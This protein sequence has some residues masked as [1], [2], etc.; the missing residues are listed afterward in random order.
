MITPELC[1]EIFGKPG[2]AF[3]RS[4]MALWNVPQPVLD[5]IKNA[6]KRIYCHKLMVKPLN[7][8]F[9]NLIMHCV[10]DELQTWDGCFNVRKMRGGTQMSIHSWGLAIDVNAK[11]N[12]LGV[13]PT[14]SKTFVKCFTDAG[15]DWG[16]TWTR[17][18][19]MHFQ[20]SCV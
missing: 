13:K 9:E 2:V 7:K 14:L 3:E 6:P 11:T 1:E 18:D 17:K 8:A 15:F 5:R 4:Y 10:E 16:G 12:A 20:L 19:G